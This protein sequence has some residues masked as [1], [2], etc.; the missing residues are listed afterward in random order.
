MQYLGNNLLNIDYECKYTLATFRQDFNY[1]IGSDFLK[2]YRQLKILI[3]G[4]K[5]IKL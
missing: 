3:I 4:N 1:I 2:N 5:N